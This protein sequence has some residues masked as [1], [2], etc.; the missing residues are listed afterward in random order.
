MY[1]IRTVQ[2]MHISSEPGKYS[3]KRKKKSLRESLSQNMA[4]LFRELAKVKKKNKPIPTVL[5]WSCPAPTFI[6]GAN[7]RHQ[8]VCL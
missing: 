4:S 1:K 6:V 3:Y 8:D 7:Q 2:Y 5:S